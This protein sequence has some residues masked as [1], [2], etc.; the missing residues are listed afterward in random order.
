MP[1]TDAFSK[2]FYNN[3]ISG[4]KYVE[5]LIKS[6]QEAGEGKEASKA[7]KQMKGASKLLEIVRKGERID[8]DN[9]EGDFEDIMG[10]FGE[11]ED[12]QIY[13]DLISGAETRAQEDPKSPSPALRGKVKSEVKRIEGA[14]AGAGEE[15]KEEQKPS[16]STGSG[17]KPPADSKLSAEDVVRMRDEA[18]AEAE[19]K[20]EDE[21]VR[22]A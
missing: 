21:A 10:L 22:K 15:E 20:A 7:V 9:M 2:P 4:K 6:V 11:M 14:G 19:K 8:R 5:N 17:K 3:K 16:V 1:A 18:R 12:I 13:N